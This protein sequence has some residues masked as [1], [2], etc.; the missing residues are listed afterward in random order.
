MDEKQEISH[1]EL[2]EINAFNRKTQLNRYCNQRIKT[3]LTSKT[4]PLLQDAFQYWKK[5]IPSTFLRESKIIRHTWFDNMQE[6]KQLYKS[7]K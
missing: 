3:H 2:V 5:E 6:I 1:S 7:F 4:I